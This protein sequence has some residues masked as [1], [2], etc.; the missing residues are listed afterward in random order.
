MN[1]FDL[2]AKLTL[3]TSE[4]DQGLN[5]SEK[6]A[7]SFG[8]GLKTAGKIGLGAMAAVGTATIAAGAALVKGT[9][10]VAS[11][12]DNID[13]MSQKLGISA[14]AYQEWD[15]ILQHSGTSIDAL[16]APMR[17]MTKAAQDGSSAFAKLGIS[18]DEVKTLSQ[19][20]LFSRVITGLQNMGEGA[21]RTALA[22]ELLGRGSMELGALLNTSAEDTEA[23]R[24]RVH[25]LGGVM[26]N[27][28]V[29][30]AANYQDSLKDMQTA[31]GGLKRNMMSEF[32]PALTE[33]MDGLTLVFSGDGDGGVAKI[34]NGI[35][36]I[37]TSLTNAIPN[38]L[39]V[40]GKIVA[41]LAQAILD[42]APKIFKAISDLI[43][44]L[45]QKFIEFLPQIASVGLSL[46]VTLA[47]A[48]VDNLPTLIPALVSVITEIVTML[49][50]P[51][52]I[53]QLIDVGIALLGALIEG[54][55]AAIPTLITALPQII[56]NIVT[57]LVEG[58]PKIVELGAS[59][60]TSLWNGLKQAFPN[61]S[62]N[63]SATWEAVKTATTEKWNAIKTSI[64]E[65]WDGIKTAAGEKI[66][67]IKTAISEKF[68]NIR[69]TIVGTFET[70]KTNVGEKWEAIK[71]KIGEFIQK[72]KDLFNFDWKFPSIKLP[73][74]YVKEYMTVLGAKIPKKLGVDWYKK[75]YEE[76][77]LFTTPT[78]IGNR[79]FGDGGGSGE[80]VYGK[81]ALM[82]DIR[83]AVGFSGNVTINVYQQPG[84]DTMELSRRI[85]QDLLKIMQRGKAGALYV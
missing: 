33:V 63:V 49:T 20:D 42:N 78:V 50:N 53:L 73:H 62:K 30:S 71:E 4:Y 36:S 67:S 6:K 84:E 61:L 47:T 79:G 64:S 55:I 35:D 45:T 46:I 31:F 11:Y 37:I 43:M 52:T 8:K 18:Q 23:M 9:G 2:A 21:D 27:E 3:D 54:I 13:K 48:L 74:I 22:T 65:V 25:E 57:T 7:S 76:P 60:I 56:T 26:S 16:K 34:S 80:I 14:E 70:L 44:T 58:L 32:M 72:I 69:E 17:T 28:A 39:E 41:A 77:Y 82:K 40:G 1:V 38:V 29:K 15:A 83:E 85:E 59:V 68:E 24:R 51:D 12:G 5:N 66:E 19:E 75:A 81:D 10:E